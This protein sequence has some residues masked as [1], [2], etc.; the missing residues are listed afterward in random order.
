MLQRCYEKAKEVIKRNC[1]SNGL[2]ASIGYDALWT[3]DSMISLIGASLDK[4]K[5][6]REAFKQSLITLKKHQS[7][8]GQIPNAV[9][10]FGK[11]KSHVDYQ[12]ID[13]TLWFII[14]EHVYKERYKD[15]SLFNK[16]KKAIS[17]ALTWLSYQDM[18]EDGMLEQLPTTD[19]QDAF[20]HKY[21][22]IINTQA[23]YYRV[24]ILNGEKE[25]AKKLKAVVNEKKGWK[26]WNKEFYIAWRWKNHN[27]YKEIGSWFDSLGNIL[28]IIFDLADKEKAEKILSHI[29]KQKIDMPYPVKAIYPPIKKGSKDWQDYFKDCDAG[30]PY[31]YLNG[32]IWPYIGG[33]YVL[34]LI[35]LKK[36]KQA[37]EQ[38]QKLAESNL[39]GNFPEW[40]SP[41]NKKGYGKFQ[42]W[43]AGIYIAAFNSLKRK[44]VLF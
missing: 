19:W 10:K 11:R 34:A 12:S 14:G 28:A 2:F 43:N 18:S 1:F 9:D 30:K 27:Q 24:L 23:L 32:G 15:S 26:L 42:A 5:K 36:F 7:K 8:L 33:F 16:H 20:P 40:I 21:G 29:K 25:K 39:R 13:S 3:R 6:F 38:L 41:L 31:H 4:E 44:K 37:E 17:K 35:K 22:H